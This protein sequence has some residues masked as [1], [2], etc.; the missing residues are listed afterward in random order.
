MPLCEENSYG[1]H[2]FSGSL[3]PFQKFSV[4]A[5]LFLL[6]SRNVTAASL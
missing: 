3:H 4:T 2:V 5:F 1:K 6:L